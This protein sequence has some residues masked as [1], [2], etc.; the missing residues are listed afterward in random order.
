MLDLPAATEI[1]QMYLVYKLFVNYKIKNETSI[2][3]STLKIISKLSHSSFVNL[4]RNSI[5]W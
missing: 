5:S 3:G 1:L 4:T 2:A